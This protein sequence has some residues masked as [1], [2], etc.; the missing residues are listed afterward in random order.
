MRQFLIFRADLFNLRIEIVD[1]IE[2]AARAT[3]SFCLI[4]NQ[5][6]VQDFL[7]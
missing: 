5:L 3:P 2:G 1:N 7:D 4:P 6:G